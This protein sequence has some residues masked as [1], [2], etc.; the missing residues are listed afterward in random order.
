MQNKNADAVIDALINAGVDISH[1][2]DDKHT[3]FLIFNI[4]HNNYFMC[5]KL[6]KHGADPNVRDNNGV[7]F[8]LTFP[9]LI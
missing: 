1:P 9:L 5:E 2:I 8:N 6:L 3:T 7:S 4:H